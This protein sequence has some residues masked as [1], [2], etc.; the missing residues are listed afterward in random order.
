MDYA[1]FAPVVGYDTDLYT[2][3]N[4]TLVINLVDRDTKEIVWKGVANGNIYDLSNDDAIQEMV[5]NIFSE[6]PL[7]N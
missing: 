2:Y 5:D 6:Y 3:K 7:S 4:G 1:A